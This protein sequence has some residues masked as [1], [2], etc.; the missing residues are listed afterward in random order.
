MRK[1][2]AM[3][4]FLHGLLATL[5]FCLLIMG[6]AAAQNQPPSQAVAWEA[7]SKAA[8]TGPADVP[9]G[10]QAV[11]KIPSGMAYIPVLEAS[12]LM[13]LWGNSVGEQFQGLVISTRNDESWVVSLSRVNEGYVKDEEAQNWNAD[14]LLQSLKEGTEAQNE[15][16]LKMGIPALDVVGWVQPPR[17]DSSSHRLVWALKAV[18]RGGAAGA[19][20]TVNYNTYALGR[21]GYFEI[22]LLTGTNHI[23]QDKPIAHGLLNSFTY[24][25]GKRYEDFNAETDHIAEYGIAALIGGVAAKK[26]GLLAVLGVFLAKFAK[27]ILIGLA[28]IGAG[29]FKF[30][31]GRKTEA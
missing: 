14:E 6:H 15:E 18:E 27:V 17:Y 21:D 29:F 30:F 10:D 12:A 9:F 7:A 22:N 31:R 4:K 26:L 19:E 1:G 28:V 2:D 11:M 13:K 20:A 8:T 23:D 5:L 24:N 16:R 25:P 3:N